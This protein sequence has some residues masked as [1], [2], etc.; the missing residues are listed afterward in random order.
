MGK[1]KEESYFDG[2]KLISYGCPISI[3]CGVRSVG[4]TYYYKRR[5]VK[6]FLSDGYTWSYL[7]RY[8]EQL[9]KQLQEGGFYSDV[10]ADNWFPHHEIRINGRIMEIKGEDEKKFH[11]FGQF[12]S[13]NAFESKKGANWSQMRDLVLDE[14]IKSK[15]M[16]RYLPN[17]VEALYN[18]WDTYDRRRNLVKVT[19]LGN[20]IDM[21][22]PY[23]LEWGIAITDDMPEY[24]RWH[25]GTVALQVTRGS[26]E[27]REHVDDSDIAKVTRGTAYDAMATDNSF[28]NLSDDFVVK[29][30]PTRAKCMYGITF[31]GRTF[32]VWVDNLQ[33]EYYVMRAKRPQN[34]MVFA[35]TRDDM[36]PNMVMLERSSKLLK[37]LGRMYRY[38]YCFF[39]SVRTREQFLT[40]LQMLGQV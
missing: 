28:G 16:S 22:N 37:M 8:D 9:K 40:M 4:K 13:L 27:F 32:S 17:E 19:L 1:L 31:Q 25:N 20:A 38:G 3:A 5:A 23:F 36:R 34:V 2:G 6:R 10:I 26:A 15:G 39:D 12:F 21:I 33:G 14:F 35:L 30:L 18:L 29:A 7:R 24:T 11:T